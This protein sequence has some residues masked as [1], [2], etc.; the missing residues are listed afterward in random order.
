MTDEAVAAGE[1]IVTSGGDQIFP[2]GL[3]V[4]TVM[5]VSPRRGS[6]SQY[7]GK[8]GAN[9][10]RLEEVLVITKKEDRAPS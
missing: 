1:Q 7:P 5:K 9:L 10:N 6:F 4:G 3:T 8:A 2:K